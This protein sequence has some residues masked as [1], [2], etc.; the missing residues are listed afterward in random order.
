MTDEPLEFPINFYLGKDKN[1]EPINIMLTKA[2]VPSAFEHY[3]DFIVESMITQQKKQ[4]REIMVYLLYKYSPDAGMLLLKDL[5]KPFTQEEHEA[6]LD[7]WVA[8]GVELMD[9]VLFTEFIK[10]GNSIT[11]F[12]KPEYVNT[13]KQWVVKM[14]TP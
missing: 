5:P 4:D 9:I 2:N 12:D 13:P 7:K 3:T 8:L 6:Y 11:I 10:A 1:N 14:L